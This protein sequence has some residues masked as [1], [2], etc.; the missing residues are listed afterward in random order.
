MAYGYRGVGP[1]LLLDQ[2]GEEGFAVDVA[3]ATDH[4]VF[5]LRGVSG[6]KQHLP[7]RVRGA[8]K[9]IG[10]PD[11]ELPHVQGVE[12]VHVLQG[13][14]GL[15]HL[16]FVDMLGQGKL[17]QDPVESGVTVQFGHLPEEDLFGGISGED[18]GFG[19]DPHPLSGLFLL[20]H[21]GDGGGVVPH[22]HHG[23]A[24]GDALFP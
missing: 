20:L 11:E 23:Q 2:D 21:V 13:I 12:A 17:D 18:D 9:E 3:P 22:P 8:G 1:G 7:H 19:V 5:P 6:P 15:Y 16:T 24:G 10:I 4:H 14:D